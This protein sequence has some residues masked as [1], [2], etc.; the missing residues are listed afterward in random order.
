MERNFSL[1]DVT[2]RSHPEIL[3]YDHRDT[4]PRWKAAQHSQLHLL[5]VIA[6]AP[7]SHR[8]QRRRIHV[9]DIDPARAD[10]DRCAHAAINITVDSNAQFGARRIAPPRTERNAK[11]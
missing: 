6:F 4:I 10:F 2:K 8:D 3:R 7:V 11:L 1:R 9:S 5:L